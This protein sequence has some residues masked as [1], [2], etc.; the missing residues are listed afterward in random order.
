MSTNSE[1]VLLQERIRNITLGNIQFQSLQAVYFAL[2]V[3]LD[4]YAPPHPIII[5]LLI[6]PSEEVSNIGRPSPFAEY[7][8]WKNNNKYFE[9]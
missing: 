2:D 5:I 3:I 8:K 4:D 7:L 1:R 6:L 9:N